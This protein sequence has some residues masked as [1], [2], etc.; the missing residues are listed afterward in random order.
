MKDRLEYLAWVVIVCSYRTNYKHRIKE[1]K[2][3][4]SYKYIVIKT[5][6]LLTDNDKDMYL[7]AIENYKYLEGE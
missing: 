7:Q 6:E 5:N 1:I 3:G 4:D 2:N